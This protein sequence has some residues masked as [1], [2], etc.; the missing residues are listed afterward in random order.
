[1]NPPTVSPYVTGGKNH[2]KCN[3]DLNYASDVRTNVCLT[4][5]EYMVPGRLTKH[6][7]AVT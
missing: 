2:T 5:L 7:I 3:G 6:G 1:M 4:S